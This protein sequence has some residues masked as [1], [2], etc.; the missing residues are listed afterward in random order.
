MFKEILKI[1]PRL[2]NRDLQNMERTLN[3]RFQRVAKRFGSG[4]LS[5]IKGGG[6][7]G[8]AVG[9]IDKIL[10][11]LKEVQESIDR[12]LKVGDQ[13]STQAGQFGT[14]AGSLFRLQQ[15]AGAKGLDSD[16]LGVL[17]TK[18]Q[19]AVAQAAADPSNPTAVSNYVG[20]SDKA[21]A[22][23]E[24]IQALQKLDKIDPDAATRVQAEVFGEKQILK[25]AEFLKADFRQ[26]SDQ[27]G[28][29]SAEE[30]SAGLGKLDVLDDRRNILKAKQET[31][32]IMVKA[33][34]LNRNTIDLFAQGDQNE[35]DRENKRLGS[36]DDL[37]KIA[38]ASDKI[39]KLLEDGYLQLAPY[40]AG[41]IPKII[42]AFQ[43]TAEGVDDI[44]KLR[45]V[46]ETFKG[47]DG[48]F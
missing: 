45:G 30:L 18:F 12:A 17:I 2:E 43:T 8:L 34:A 31:L 5:A 23:F 33:R 37:K 29:P 10:N 39:V 6:V 24:F 11:P 25:M 35:L 26:L 32:D 16:S 20:K 15:M 14:T 40:I 47:K 46:R 36:V 3:S 22:F 19:T 7:V 41:S 13:A 38:M 21:E 48:A 4:L 1:I 42:K 27:I 28:G 44:K 9:I